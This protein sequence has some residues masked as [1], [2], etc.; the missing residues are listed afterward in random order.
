MHSITHQGFEGD[1]GG[2]GQFAHLLLD[3]ITLGFIGSG[4]SDSTSSFFLA[5]PSG[6]RN[7][8]MVVKNKAEL[9]MCVPFSALSIYDILSSDKREKKTV[10][11][12]YMY[13]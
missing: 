12:R 7:Q 1:G 11:Q 2:R 3:T 9:M 13:V 4:T 10:P 6:F 8:D 5:I